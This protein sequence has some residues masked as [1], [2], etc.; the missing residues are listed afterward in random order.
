MTEK[1]AND[2]IKSYFSLYNKK[3]YNYIHENLQKKKS[4]RNYIYNFSAKSSNKIFVSNGEFKHTNDKLVIEIHLFNAEKNN[5]FTAT[6]KFQENMQDKFEEKL[7][8]SNRLSVFEKKSLNFVRMLNYRWLHNKKLLFNNKEK[9]VES[10]TIQN[11]MIIWIRKFINRSLN[12]EYDKI[13]H[14]YT[15]KQMLF[16]NKSKYT[17]LYLQYLKEHLY[18][19]YNKQIEFNIINLRHFFF[20]SDILSESILTKIKRRP[21]NFKR[22]MKSLKDKVIT[23]RKNTF[24]HKNIVE[25][26]INKKKD[27]SKSHE[28]L[29]GDLMKELK[30]KNVT[31]FRLEARGRLTKRFKASRSVLRSVH[32]GSLFNI[33]SSIKGLSCVVLKGNTDSNIQFGKTVSK[34]RIGSFGLRC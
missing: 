31:G 26:K 6:Q 33:D 11:Y 8:F 21:R 25:N 20:N 30:H 1:T 19:I 18:K 3:G 32:K 27:L 4:L 17:Y 5:L 34:S 2:I 24:L 12:Y 7:F 23:A 13:L 16:T 28:I 15:Y 29:I 10:K 9:I 22:Y 14:Y